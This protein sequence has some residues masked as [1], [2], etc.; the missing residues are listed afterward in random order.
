MMFKL[1]FYVKIRFVKEESEKCV[2][3]LDLELLK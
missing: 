3:N 2:V 1:W